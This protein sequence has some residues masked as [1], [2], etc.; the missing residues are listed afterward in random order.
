MPFG[1]Q[2]DAWLF[3]A[4]AAFVLTHLAVLVYLARRN[5][6]P[7]RGSVGRAARSGVDVGASS[8]AESRPVEDLPPVE[9]ERVVECPHCGVS[10][11]G[12]FRFCR[13][14]VGELT[15]GATIGDAGGTSRDGQAF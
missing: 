15:G 11:G 14:C 7:A 3:A 13:Y 6:E 1:L 2:A 10:N 5:L 4:G 12:D 9:G 8:A